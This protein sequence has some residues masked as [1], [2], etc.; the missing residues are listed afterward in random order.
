MLYS[1]EPNVCPLLDNIQKCY[2]QWTSEKNNVNKGNEFMKD[3][4]QFQ[5]QL[6]K[7]K[8]DGKTQELQDTTDRYSL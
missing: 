6:R 8:H 2:R 3:R 4:K 5:F 7:M 1:N